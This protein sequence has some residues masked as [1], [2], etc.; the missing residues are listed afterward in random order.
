MMMENLVELR[1]AEDTEVLGENPTERHYVHHK[2]HLTRPGIELG[3]PRWEAS[4]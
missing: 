4:D 2:F 1:L 3:L